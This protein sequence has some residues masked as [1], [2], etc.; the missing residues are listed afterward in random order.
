MQF[1]HAREVIQ[2][3][4]YRFFKQIVAFNKKSQK[5]N[6]FSVGPPIFSSRTMPRLLTFLYPPQKT[7]NQR[8]HRQDCEGEQATKAQQLATRSDSLARSYS[9]AKLSRTSSGHSQYYIPPKNKSRSIPRRQ[10]AKRRRRHPSPPIT[11]GGRR[12]ERGSRRFLEAPFLLLLS[13]PG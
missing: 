12:G 7:G 11:S 10:S 4:S 6:F 5:C 1:A 3:F 13:D 8:T 2:V 9:C